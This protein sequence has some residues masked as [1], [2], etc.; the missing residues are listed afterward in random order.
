MSPFCPY[1]LIFGRKL[2]F[3]N[4]KRTCF[5]DF[6]YFLFLGHFWGHFGLKIANFQI[7]SLILLKMTPKMAQN[8]KIS[9]IQKTSSLCIPKCQFPAKNEEIWT[10]WRWVLLFRSK[11]S[12]PPNPGISHTFR[13]IS[14]NTSRLRRFISRRHSNL[15]QFRKKFLNPH[16]PNF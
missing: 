16:N 14:R 10:K 8:Q 1:F 12:D 9:K 7:L 11:F 15:F 3:W 13:E 4:T 6:W 5:L 2:A